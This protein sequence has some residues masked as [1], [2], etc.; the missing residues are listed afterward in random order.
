MRALPIVALVLGSAA[1]IGAQQAVARRTEG[2]R[3]RLGPGPG[4]LP[5]IGGFPARPHETLPFPMP[6]GPPP[7][8]IATPKVEQV[9]TCPP[10]KIALPYETT[11]GDKGWFCI[12]PP[13]QAPAEGGPCDDEGGWADELECV[14]GFWQEPA[15][16]RLCST[17]GLTKDGL[18]CA[19]GHWNHP[20]WNGPCHP[21]AA[22]TQDGTLHC[23]DANWQPAAEGRPCRVPGQYHPDQPLYCGND[24][25]WHAVAE[26]E[27]CPTNGVRG[28][29]RQ[30]LVCYEN[31]WK[32]ALKCAAA[33][34]ACAAVPI[35][36]LPRWHCWSM[37][38][39][40]GRCDI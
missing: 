27:D 19:S 31:E 32:K 9:P 1:L 5:T 37:S 33:V 20:E 30:D 25:R 22:F 4:G 11:E 28:P 13:P 12:D 16:G 24:Q 38:P 3:R 15:P 17:E 29:G 26:G 7:G 35:P 36:G 39:G 34:A 2:R 6:P 8:N 18:H 23:V 10:G 40:S 14:G 21:S